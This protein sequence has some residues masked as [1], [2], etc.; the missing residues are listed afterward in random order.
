MQAKIENLK[1]LNRRLT[2]NGLKFKSTESLPELKKLNLAAE[3]VS[4]DERL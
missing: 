2:N 1:F 3:R 4:L